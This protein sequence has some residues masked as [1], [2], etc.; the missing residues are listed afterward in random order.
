M[1]LL[2]LIKYI[3]WYATQNEMKLTTVRL[4]KFLYLADLYYARVHGGQTATGFPW[5]FVHYGPYCSEAMDAID[6]A[7]S[8]GII[9]KKTYQSKFADTDEYHIFLCYDDE[10]EAPAEYLSAV[11]VSYLEQVVRKYGEDTPALLDHV[12]FETEPMLDVRPGDQ[13]DFSLAK[14]I[15]S[16]QPIEIKTL[17]KEKIELARKHIKRLAEKTKKETGDLVSENAEIAKWMDEKYYAALEYL[18]EEDL[19][20][21]LEGVA[22]IER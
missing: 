1:N 14:P 13:L 10:V 16:L 2:D 22:R 6:N 15:E 8:D 20:P 17:P 11:I 7:V 4:V 18:D 12:Y 21:G 5:G 9:D 19:E 3:V